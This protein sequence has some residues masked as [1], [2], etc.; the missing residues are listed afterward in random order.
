MKFRSIKFWLG[1]RVGFRSADAMSQDDG[2]ITICPLCLKGRNNEI[3]LLLSCSSME[4]TRRTIQMSTGKTLEYTLSEICTRYSCNSDQEVERFLKWSS[5]SDKIGGKVIWKNLN[6]VL[7]LVMRFLTNKQVFKTH[8]WGE[9]IF[10]HFFFVYFEQTQ[11]MPL[12]RI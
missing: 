4:R 10:F 11:M 3:H 12:C 1:N 2:R 9:N 8:S 6:F 5:Q 7:M